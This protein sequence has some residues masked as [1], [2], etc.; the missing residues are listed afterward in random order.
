MSNQCQM[1][2]MPK[3]FELLEFMPHLKLIH[4]ISFSF[5]TKSQMEAPE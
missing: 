3:F 2:E 4:L 1:K 5:L